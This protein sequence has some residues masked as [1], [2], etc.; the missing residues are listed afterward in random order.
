MKAFENYEIA[1]IEVPTTRDVMETIRRVEPCHADPLSRDC[2]NAQGKDDYLLADMKA[3][4]V[5]Q[6]CPTFTRKLQKMTAA[7]ED[8]IVAMQDVYT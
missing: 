3:V 8:W 2:T 1:S 5:C 4:D 6:G 7:W